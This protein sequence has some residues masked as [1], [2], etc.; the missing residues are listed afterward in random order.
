MNCLFL[1]FCY[2]LCGP[3]VMLS[4]FVHEKTQ[5]RSNKLLCT[6]SCCLQS[7]FIVWFLWR[8]AFSFLVIYTT[9]MNRWAWP[10]IG[11]NIS[12]FYWLTRKFWIVLG[13]LKQQNVLI[14]QWPLICKKIKGILISHFMTPL[15]HFN[16]L[17][18]SNY[19]L[20]FVQVTLIDSIKL[21]FICI[22][23]PII[24]K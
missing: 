13:V 15:I 22:T 10:Q 6:A 12:C 16:Q 24:A 20:H 23:I 17:Y 21:K 19:G 3:F 7:I 14:V 9:C 11:F 4:R 5:F 18:Q 8:P 2:V 1:L